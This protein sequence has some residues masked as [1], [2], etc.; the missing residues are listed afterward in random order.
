MFDAKIS[1]GK[2]MSN[3][4]TY[5]FDAT[6]RQLV[7]FAKNI[8]PK[9]ALL[10]I[11]PGEKR[12]GLAVSDN[13][14]MIATPL[15]TLE[16]T[17]LA[18]DIAKITTIIKERNIGGIVCG[19]PLEM[20]GNIGTSAEK[21]AKLCLKIIAETKLSILLWDERLSTSAVESFLIKE[22]DLSRQKRAKVVD[23]NAAAFILQGAIDAIKKQ[24]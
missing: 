7:E 9:K 22:A 14:L 19:Y 3:P 2:K 24:I 16:R 12:L 11:D 13:L 17:S 4:D 10:G 6:K 1:L 21:A 18:K 20:N 23:R 5:L 15:L 8:P